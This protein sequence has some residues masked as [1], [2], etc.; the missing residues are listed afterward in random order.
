MNKNLYVFALNYG[1]MGQIEGLF[2]A[3]KEDL[4]GA[5]GRQCYFGE[6]LGK[7]SEVECEF[8]PGMIKLMSDDQPLIESL[9]K[10][11]GNETII[12]FNPLAYLSE[13]EDEGDE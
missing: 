2:I 12:G 6:V 4:E 10:L 5:Y 7:H 11:F 3:N 9:E 1:R 8:S 13:D